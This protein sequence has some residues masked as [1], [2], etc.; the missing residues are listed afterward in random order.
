VTHLLMWVVIPEDHKAH[1]LEE[2]KP[3]S[4]QKVV[5][6]KSQAVEKARAAVAE[7]WEALIRSQ[8]LAATQ[9]ALPMV[10]HLEEE[11]LARHHKAER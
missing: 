2:D 1:L 3:W 5:E 7:A 10:H 4:T 8:T 11:R 9:A 6:D